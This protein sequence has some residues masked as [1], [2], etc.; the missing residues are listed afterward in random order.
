VKT[1]EVGISRELAAKL[2]FT[3]SSGEPFRVDLVYDSAPV[4]VSFSFALPPQSEEEK[5]RAR[6]ALADLV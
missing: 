4:R 1:I 6:A 3:E 2:A 5:E